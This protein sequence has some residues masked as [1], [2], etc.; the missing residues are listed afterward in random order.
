MKRSFT[1]LELIFVIIVIGILAAVVIPRLRTDSLTKATTIFIDTLRYTQHLAMVDD[2]YTPTKALSLY[3]GSTKKMKDTKFWFKKW[4][5]FY[6]NGANSHPVLV[7]FSDTP[8]ANA[9]N[10]EFNYYPYYDEVA[11]GGSSGKKMMG[12]SFNAP[13]DEK[14]VDRSL[15]LLLSYGIKKVV[16]ETPCSHNKTKLAFDEL[17]RPHCIQQKSSSNYTPYRYILDSKIKYTLCKDD[18]CEENSSLCIVARSGYIYR[19]D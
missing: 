5:M 8:S 13:T 10:S 3:S 6:I 16:I 11:N 9:A 1:L 17:G 14:Y 18:G 15:D 19:C 4:W 7:V 2:K 12:K